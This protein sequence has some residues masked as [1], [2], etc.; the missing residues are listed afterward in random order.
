MMLLK[1][2]YTGRGKRQPEDTAV[3]GNGREI[4]RKTKKMTE[5]GIIKAR[6]LCLKRRNQSPVLSP[7]SKIRDQKLIRDLETK[8]LTTVSGNSWGWFPDCNGL[9]NAQRMRQG[10]NTF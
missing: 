9:G 7:I 3:E 2:L 6:R 4:E 10:G 5:R 8:H 1:R